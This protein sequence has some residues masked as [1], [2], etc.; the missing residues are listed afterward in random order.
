[1]IHSVLNVEMSGCEFYQN[2][3]QMALIRIYGSKPVYLELD[4][5]SI[6]DNEVDFSTID[7]ESFNSESIIIVTNCLFSNNTSDSIL[8]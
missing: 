1:M 8:V 3:G 2:T 5:C 4:N 6:Y 7:M